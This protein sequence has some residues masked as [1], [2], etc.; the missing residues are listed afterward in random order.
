MK[1]LILGLA[2]SGTTALYYRVLHSWPGDVEVFSRFEPQKWVEPEKKDGE[3]GRNCLA[4][5]LVGPPDYA[6]YPS[7]AGFDRKVLIVRDPRDTL[8]SRI[9]YNAYEFPP[10]TNSEQLEEYVALIEKKVNDPESVSLL[11][12]CAMMLRLLSPGRAQRGGN[13]GKNSV[14]DF[15]AGGT[16]WQE[17]VEA[18]FPDLFPIRYEDFIE[19]HLEGLERFL[20]FGLKGQKEVAATHHRVSRS[21]SSGEWR[22]WFSN[23]DWENFLPAMKP[24]L[25]KWNYPLEVKPVQESID[26]HTSVG[27]LR[28]LLK[29]REEKL[30]R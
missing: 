2:K 22:R 3:G 26:P 18:F 10:E 1:I 12:I 13:P 25:E 28:N 24:F 14:L 20:G 4:K 27:Y 29:L 19:D 11:E 16:A 5:V 8:I 7:F 17:K 9:L 30:N 21:R 15:A 6:D 23:E